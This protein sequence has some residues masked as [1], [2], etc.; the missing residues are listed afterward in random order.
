MSAAYLTSPESTSVFESAE[1]AFTALVERAAS[2]EWR[3]LHH[4]DVEERL[5]RE[6]REVLRH[7]MDGHMALRGAGQVEEVV[8]GSDEIERP[9]ERQSNRT[10]G[11][12]LGPVRVSRTGYGAHGAKNLFVVDADL[13]LPADKH[14]LTVR[15]RAT[16]FA[17]QS[18]FETATEWLRSTTGA[19]AGKRQVEELVMCSAKDFEAFYDGT[20]LDVAGEETGA[21]MALTFDMKGV[22][23][24]EEDLRTKTRAA[25]ARD[26]PKP[27]LDKGKGGKRLHRKRMAMVASVYTV[28]PWVRT[29]EHVA[30][31][32]CR[33]RRDDDEADP[34][35]RCEYKRVWASLERE[36]QRV[37]DE[38]FEEGL[39]RDPDKKKTWVVL[40]DGDAKQL[41]WVKKAARRYKV[42]VRI[43]LDIIHV[44]QYL[45]KAGKAL[46]CDPDQREELETWVGER[47]L[48][49]LKGEAGLVAGGMRR[50]ATLRGLS[51]EARKPIDKCAKY[52]K[53]YKKYLGYDEALADGTP[54]G[55]GVIEGAC[56]HLI[57]D[58]MDITGARW[59]LE[60][61]EAML[62]IRA[63]RSSGDF[64][65]YWH[66]HRQRE[67]ERNHGVL[68]AHGMHPPLS[69]PT[70]Y[71]HL[72]LVG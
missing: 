45:W 21:V 68:Y 51:I 5:E 39:S 63:L 66:F 59:S 16:E 34:R 18:S 9:H 54:I 26:Q 12:I 50:S 23:L 8:V 52:L 3:R 61:A 65:D 27:A 53:K 10:L 13:N 36:P 22:V 46:H 49:V 69:Y 48:R 43:V 29:P 1:N 33:I 42:K 14:S 58:R 19:T 25:A 72:R 24:R 47:L 60:G 17:S 11:T 37:I 56:R 70:R 6:G 2:T 64:D 44:T 15:R 31:A 7:L 38:A 67:Y 41:K 55:T 4:D 35:P 71:A 28:A 40:V 62:K 20:A 57:A 32:L 30:D